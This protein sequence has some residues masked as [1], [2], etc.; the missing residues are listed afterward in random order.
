MAKRYKDL[1]TD[2]THFSPNSVNK[3]LMRQLFTGTREVIKS[4]GKALLTEHGWKF[5]VVDQGRGRCYFRDK[6]ITIPA[7][8]FAK[9]VDYKEWYIAHEMAHAMQWIQDKRS[10]QHG[11]RFMAWLIKICP[12]DCVHYELEYKPRN[13]MA[14]GITKPKSDIDK[15][16]GF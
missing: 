12:P 15:L 5:Y 16:C 11:E 13:A 2:E 8:V 3:E 9:S 6:V 14:A 10:D 4:Y 1:F 7:W